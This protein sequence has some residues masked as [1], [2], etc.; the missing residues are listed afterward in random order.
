[1][2]FK[3]RSYVVDNIDE[4][5][6]DSLPQAQQDKY[7]EQRIAPQIQDEL[8]D[9]TFENEDEKTKVYD[10]IKSIKT[11]KEYGTKNA[12]K[13]LP[14][15]TKY[16][17]NEYYKQNYVSRLQEI[18]NQDSIKTR[19]GT[20]TNTIEN[21]EKAKELLKAI[22]IKTAI[23]IY[24]PPIVSPPPTA[25]ALPTVKVETAAKQN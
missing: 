14:F 15:D 5:I 7:V 3:S 12:D 2:V 19:G 21:K 10:K 18:I 16:N 13:L 4:D 8:K 1:M 6:M 11:A 17:D 23:P 9:I 24:V 20:K 25:E 22:G